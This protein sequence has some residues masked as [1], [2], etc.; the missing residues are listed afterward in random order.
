[1]PTETVGS[2]ML[3]GLNYG[4]AEARKGDTVA[5]FAHR[6]DITEEDFFLFNDMPS[7]SNAK[8]NTVLNFGEEYV[9]KVGGSTSKTAQAKKRL[10]TVRHRK[11]KRPPGTGAGVTSFLNRQAHYEHIRK[12]NL[13]LN[14]RL[15]EIYDLNPDSF[16]MKNKLGKGFNCNPK[17]KVRTR[18]VICVF[19]V[20]LWIHATQ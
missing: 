6:H 5:S 9:V 15:K 14:R 11:P 8:G 1:M 2:Y 16:M 20:K 18:C 3:K 7:V 4:F 13:K 10:P 12:G 19:R 17:W